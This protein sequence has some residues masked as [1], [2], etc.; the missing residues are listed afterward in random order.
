MEIASCFITGETSIQSF[1]FGFRF[2]F[3]VCCVICLLYWRKFVWVE[4]CRG[5]SPAENGYLRI[6]VRWCRHC[7]GDF[8]AL[9]PFA[10]NIVFVWMKFSKIGYFEGDWFFPSQRRFNLKTMGVGRM[11]QLIFTALKVRKVL[12][13]PQRRTCQKRHRHVRF[14]IE[15]E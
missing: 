12:L 6:F 1:F 14:F 15:W 3:F 10:H 2:F 8:F 7:F 13:Q 11:A 5:I 4:H 9:E